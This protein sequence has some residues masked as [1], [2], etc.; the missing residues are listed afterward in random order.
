MYY[1][2]VIDSVSV[3]SGLSVKHNARIFMLRKQIE[4]P[5]L[6][7]FPGADGR[8]I[9]VDQKLKMPRPALFPIC[10][11]ARPA[12][13]QVRQGI[14]ASGPV[15]GPPPSQNPPVSSLAF[16]AVLVWHSFSRSPLLSSVFFFSSII[17][18]ESLPSAVKCMKQKVYRQKN[19]HR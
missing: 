15:P 17:S 11:P 10:P 4:A 12:P 7:A 5:M 1:N 16:P 6:R 2:D 9:S 8:C 3:I 14:S 13:S 18:S 19:Q